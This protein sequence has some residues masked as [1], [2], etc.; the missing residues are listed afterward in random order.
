LAGAVLIALALQFGGLSVVE[1]LLFGSSEVVG[2]SRY[3][4]GGYRAEVLSVERQRKTFGVRFA[5]R[6]KRDLRA[7]GHSC[8]EIRGSRRV[9]PFAVRLNT[10]RPGRYAGTMRFR[11]AGSGAYRFRYS[12]RRDYTFALLFRR[13]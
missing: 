13:R 12:C 1:D 2:V 7:P 9:R 8:V 4:R 6:G 3:K 11:Y 10:R 5:A